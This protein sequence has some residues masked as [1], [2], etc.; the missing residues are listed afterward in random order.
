MTSDAPT[1]RRA[2][3]LLALLACYVGVVLYSAAT[4][5]HQLSLVDSLHAGMDAEADLLLA[6]EDQ[7]LT[8]C[9]LLAA[10]LLCGVFFLRWLAACNRTLRHLGEGDRLR[11][12]PGWTVGY[13]F[14]PFLNLVRPYQG[15]SDL[16]HASAPRSVDRVPQITPAL[17]P[18]WWGGYLVSG[19][20][21]RIAAKQL[22]R[23]EDLASLQDALGLLL[24]SDFLDLVSAALAMLLVHRLSRR[25]EARWAEAGG[26]T[27]ELP[28]ASVS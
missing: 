21:D 2:R 18:L 20:L 11:Q 16:W 4:D 7:E 12:T 25:V 10:L 24:V 3:I 22:M 27:A 19:F 14:I 17:L 23:A 5:W 8:A 9:A 26:G 28:R 1:G 13:F 15:V 6:S